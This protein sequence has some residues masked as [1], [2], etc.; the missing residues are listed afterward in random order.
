MIEFWC[1][2]QLSLK[3]RCVF[4]FLNHLSS[5]RVNSTKQW[6]KTSKKA[7]DVWSL[8][9][10]RFLSKSASTCI[11]LM[12]MRCINSAKSSFCLNGL[13]NYAL[14]V[15]NTNFHFLKPM[16]IPRQGDLFLYGTEA[17]ICPINRKGLWVG[18]LGW[19]RGRARTF[20]LSS[21]LRSLIFR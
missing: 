4:L 8:K 3:T 18:C 9:N 1:L 13:L 11:C 14:V 2:T 21:F 20:F 6:P 19:Q 16:L 5:C 7:L 12:D 10:T 17:L 15:A